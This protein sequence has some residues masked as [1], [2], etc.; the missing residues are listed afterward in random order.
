MIGSV[1][2]S[3]PPKCSVVVPPKISSG[4][5]TDVAQERAATFQL[6]LEVGELTAAQ[7]AYS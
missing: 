2:C 6:V 7:A 3:L 4:Q 1:F 5:S